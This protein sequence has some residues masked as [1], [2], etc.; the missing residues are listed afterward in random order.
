MPYHLKLYE[1]V[2]SGINDDDD[3]EEESDMNDD[4]EDYFA[5]S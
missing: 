3:Q 4:G 1:L 2:T 5:F